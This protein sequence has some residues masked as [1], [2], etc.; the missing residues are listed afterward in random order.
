[1]REALIPCLSAVPEKLAQCRESLRGIE[2][3]KLFPSE[4]CHVLFCYFVDMVYLH[5]L[6]KVPENTPLTTCRHGE[7]T[8]LFRSVVVYELINGWRYES[9]THELTY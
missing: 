5:L 3:S 8:V 2:T 4:K 7:T 9:S 1:M 6:G